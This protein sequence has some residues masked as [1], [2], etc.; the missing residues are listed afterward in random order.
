[1]PHRSRTIDRSTTV[2][3]PPAVVFAVVMSPET[4][5][6]IDPAVRVWQADVRPIQLGTRFTIRGR[7][8]VVPIR[9]TSELTAWDPPQ[10]AEFRSIAPTWPFRMTARHQFEPTPDGGTDYTWSI[11]FH[12]VNALARPRIAILTRLFGHALAAQAATLARY[13]NQRSVNEP[14]PPL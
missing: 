1:M 12:E 14:L 8:G 13:L 10:L 4:A 3:S 7:L 5:R 6:L 9:G 11:S 2:G